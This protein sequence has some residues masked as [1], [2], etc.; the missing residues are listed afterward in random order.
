MERR[1]KWD[2]TQCSY[3]G[4]TNTQFICWQCLETSLDELRSEI[5]ALQTDLTKLQEEITANGD[6]VRDMVRQRIRQEAHHP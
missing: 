2:P 5:K 6:K 1:Q 3:C 4:N